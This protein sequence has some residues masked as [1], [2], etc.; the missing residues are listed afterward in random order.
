MWIAEMGKKTVGNNGV[1]TVIYSSQFAIGSLFKSQNGSIWTANQYQDLKFKLYKAK[2]TT[3][4]GTV[5]FYNPSLNESNGYIQ[6]LPAN[7]LR[8]YPKKLKVGITTITNAPGIGILTTGRKV[9]ESSKT[10]NY[11]YIVGTGCS[12]YSVGITTGGVG[13]GTQS[14]VSTYAITGQGSG[15]T[16]NIAASNGIIN[17]VT[18]VIRGNGYVV[19]DVIG[20]VTSTAGN[21]GR[22]AQLTITGITTGIDTLYLTNVQGQSFTTNANLIYYDDSNNAITL[23]STTITNSTSQTDQNTGN[24]L[25]VSHYNH[26]MY[27]NNNKLNINSVLSNTQPA[28]LQSAI[29]ISATS[30]QIGIANTVRFATFE[31]MPVSA[32]NPGYAKIENE[33]IKYESVGSGILQ[34]VSRGIDS[35]IVDSYSSGTLIYKYELN[36]ISLRRINTSHDISNFGIDTDSYYL[37]IDRSTNGIDRSVDNS[38]S[39]FPQL[40][41]TDEVLLGGTE[42]LATENIQFDS[43]LPSYSILNPGSTTSASAVIRTVSGTS[44]DGTEVSFIDQGFETVELN[45]LNTLSST[46]IVCS[47]INEQTYLSNLPRNKSFTTGI[48][49]STQNQNLSPQIFTDNAFTEFRSN[50][51]N[52]PVGDYSLDNLVKTVSDDP[53]SAIYISNTIDL[54]YP[55][56]SLKVILSANRPASS[57]FRVLY[58]LI[59]ADSNGINQSFELFPGY[60]NLIDINGDGFGDVVVNS[61][62]NSGRPDALVSPNTDGSYSEYQFTAENLDQFVGYTIKIVISGTD[63]SKPVLIKDLRTI[64]IR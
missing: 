32:T 49:L 12:V 54:K 58:R 55:A 36:G 13:Y 43:V 40:S 61:S 42:V 37:E 52:S 24:F 9:S 1:D 48:T 16:V 63:Q 17:G 35:T 6:K 23:G 57:D 64:A 53:H 47:K 30:I 39:G 10:Y 31:G 59:R 11:G 19:G 44:V 51:I 56:T 5:Y 38:P 14:N 8:S 45:K 2:F 29:N 60:D 20:I 28:T 18:P 34:S 33:I 50:R 27:S 26:G 3:T 4:P 25:Q 15:L 22:D 46:R 21:V 41:F 7:P 62:K